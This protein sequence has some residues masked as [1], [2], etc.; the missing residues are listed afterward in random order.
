MVTPVPN[1]NGYSCHTKDTG[2]M[3]VIKYAYNYMVPLLKDETSGQVLPK[4]D[5]SLQVL[6]KNDTSWQQETNKR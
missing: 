6:L 2:Y 4:D 3:Y 1:D 5:I